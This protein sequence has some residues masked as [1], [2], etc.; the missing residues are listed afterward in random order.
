LRKRSEHRAAAARLLDLVHLAHRRTSTATIASM[1]EH[2]S[3]GR[4]AGDSSVAKAIAGMA[5]WARVKAVVR[6]RN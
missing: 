1:A 3:A 4:R 5:R 2:S 6:E